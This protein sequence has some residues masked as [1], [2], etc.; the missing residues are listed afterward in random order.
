MYV[1]VPP[2]ETGAV[3]ISMIA[4]GGSFGTS[5][6]QSVQGTIDT[7][8]L[9]LS[10]GRHTVYVVGSDVL[11]YEGAFSAIFLDIEGRTCIDAGSNSG[12]DCLV[13][14]DCC[15]SATRRS[16]RGLQGFAGQECKRTPCCSGYFCEN[17]G[18]NVFVCV[19]DGTLSPTAGPT[20]SVKPSPSPSGIQSSKPSASLKPSISPSS[21]PSSTPST[22]QKPIVSISKQP[23][24]N[25]ST[26]FMPSVSKCRCDLPTDSPTSSPTPLPTSAPTS[27]PTPMPTAAPQIG[28]PCDARGEACVQGSES[29]CCSGSCSTK[30]RNYKCD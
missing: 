6:S 2:W 20:T 1:D 9:G 11:G 22:S 4:T 27:P 8:S 17:Q 15:A 13:D 14:E 25:P 5:T 12:N 30:G 19:Q 26:S 7:G 23:S 16:L 3:P 24:S 10:P 29:Q 21:N 28:Q 18:K